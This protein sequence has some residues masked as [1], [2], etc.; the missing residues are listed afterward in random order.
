LLLVQV[1]A[2]VLSAAA[3]CPHLQALSLARC[4][5]VDDAALT[6][7]AALSRTGQQQQQQGCSPVEELVL[8]E[9]AAVSDAG[10]LA[11]LGA[12]RQLRLLSLR[13]CARLTD[14][15]LVPAVQ[16]GTLEVLSANGLHQLSSHML[17]E[18]SRSC[19]E[20]LR[21]LDVSFCRNFAEGALGQLVDSCERLSVLK[22]Y[23]CSQLT[24]R[25]LHG[26]SNKNLV[27]VLGVGTYLNAQ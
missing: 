26:H 10:L 14:A 17:T 8:D 25:F 2:A 19:R 20:V 5:H 4:P 11:M 6:A 1:D 24:A 12:A 21:E 18:L 13:R 9:C 7:F 23:G 22:V 16:R 27:Q 15:S 3:G